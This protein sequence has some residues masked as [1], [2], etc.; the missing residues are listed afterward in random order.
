MFYMKRRH[1]MGGRNEVQPRMLRRRVRGCPEVKRDIDV[2][3][4]LHRLGWKGVAEVY[5]QTLQD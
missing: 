4:A 2:R 1:A 3:Q 5:I